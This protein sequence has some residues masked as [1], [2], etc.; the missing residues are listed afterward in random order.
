MSEGE[1]QQTDRTGTYL[2]DGALK[3]HGGFG[4]TALR[5][6]LLRLGHLLGALLLR[7][8]LLLST[9]HCTFTPLRVRVCVCVVQMGDGLSGSGRSNN[10]GT[11]L[12]MPEMEEATRGMNY[13]AIKQ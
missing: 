9:R 12:L 7:L 8:N 2:A 4:G 10:A 1:V 3:V 6:R 11:V 5:R 13:K